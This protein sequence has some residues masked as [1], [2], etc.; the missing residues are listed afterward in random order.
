MAFDSAFNCGFM[1]CITP[2]I[3][4]LIVAILIMLVFH[5]FLYFK[6]VN[7]AKKRF[8]DEPLL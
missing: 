4:T 5:V 1:D 2:C 3:I 6:F 8:G 7:L